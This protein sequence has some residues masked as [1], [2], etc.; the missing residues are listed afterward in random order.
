MRIDHD[1]PSPR[2]DWRGVDC[3]ETP[4]KEQNMETAK[5]LVALKTIQRDLS[6]LARRPVGSQKPTVE[7]MNNWQKLVNAALSQASK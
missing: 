2:L 3:I 1:H 4:T 5:M 7:T 6:L